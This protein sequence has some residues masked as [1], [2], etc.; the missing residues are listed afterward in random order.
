MQQQRQMGYR[1]M[2]D[3]P[4][5]SNPW[6]VSY[7]A[8][9]ERHAD[10]FW[11]MGIANFLASG[12]ALISSLLMTLKRAEIIQEMWHDGLTAA[13]IEREIAAITADDA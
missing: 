1:I 7:I 4:D 8:Q 2:A 5:P 6:T 12:E 10:S 9:H 11:T 13:E 3:G